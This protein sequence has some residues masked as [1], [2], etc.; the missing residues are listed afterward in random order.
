MEEFGVVKE[1]Y[2]GVQLPQIK[3]Y[4]VE[5]LESYDTIHVTACIAKSMGVV[6]KWCRFTR[7]LNGASHWAFNVQ[8]S[9]ISK[10]H[11][12]HTSLRSHVPG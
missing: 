3:A 11:F 5:M 6:S 7:N 1:S 12:A 8:S 2:D 9:H 10:L 4:Q